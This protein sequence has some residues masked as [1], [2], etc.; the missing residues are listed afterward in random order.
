MPSE[1]TQLTCSLKRKA[2]LGAEA[3]ASTPTVTLA[4]EYASIRPRISIRLAQAILRAVQRIQLVRSRGKKSN[5]MA[6]TR[7]RKVISDKIGN[8]SLPPHRVVHDN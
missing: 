1:G 7:G 4:C 6:P 2:L 5:P 8:M 3:T